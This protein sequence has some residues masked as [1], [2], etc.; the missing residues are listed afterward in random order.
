MK[1]PIDRIIT[2]EIMLDVVFQNAQE[3]SDF[4]YEALSAL[5]SWR[6]GLAA[7]KE[8]CLPE[9]HVSCLSIQSE[10]WTAHPQGNRS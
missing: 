2:T 1:P 3:E 10:L 4:I 6:P 9:S 8:W 5:F 7:E